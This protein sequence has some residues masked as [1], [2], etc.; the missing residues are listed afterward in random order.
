[1]TKGCDGITW[2][3]PKASLKVNAHRTNGILL[4][5]QASVLKMAE[6][7][8]SSRCRDCYAWRMANLGAMSS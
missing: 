6:K 3:S 4:L 8:F 1:M 5:L 2:L 7:V